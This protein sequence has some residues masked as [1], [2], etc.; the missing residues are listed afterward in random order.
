MIDRR[1]VVNLVAFFALSAVLVSYGIVT[2]FG[3]PFE[4][5]RTV[6]T[7]LPEAGGLL[8]GFSASHD[9]VI[10]GRVASVDLLEERVRVTVALDRGVTIPEGVEAR[11]VRAS[12]VGEQRLD[13][14]SV[15]G[16][17]TRPLADGAR[18]SAGEHP[19][20]PDVADVLETTVA[21]IEALPADDLN[22]LVREAAA[23]LEGR[24]DDLQ[25]ITRSLIVI[26]DDVVALEAP[27]RR[28]LEHGPPVLD[29]FSA[30]SPQ[31]RSALATTEA[32]TE[33]LAERRHDLVDLLDSGGDL[34]VVGDEVVRDTRAGLTCLIGD[35]AS[36]TGGLQGT[37]LADLDEALRTNT[38]FFG[39]V[40]RLAV[41]GPTRDVGYGPGRPDQLWLRTS[42]L[43]PPQTPAASAYVPPRSP[44]PVVTGEGCVTPFGEGVTAT[45]PPDR[46]LAARPPTA[47]PAPVGPGEGT[48]GGLLGPVLSVLPTAQASEPSPP[49]PD[50]VP[51]VILSA[52]VLAAVASLVPATRRRRRAP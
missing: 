23:A 50:P 32:L 20:P 15:P 1:I 43:L 8:P 25:S 16:G 13:L 29:D 7:E 12:A 9:G 28:L 31:V 27:L 40:E 34:A 38:Q 49:N 17:S 36:I 2:L 46:D 24:A 10:V 14:R 45:P 26:S 33:I 39:L 30:M 37:A 22:T 41:R 11:V 44:R 42:L 5:R 4:Q 52:G 48:G 19:V 35:L 21:L 51:L 47:G 18:V 3:S 6:V